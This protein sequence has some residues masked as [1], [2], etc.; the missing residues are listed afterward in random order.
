MFCGDGIKQA[1]EKCDDGNMNGQ[2]GSNCT[3]TCQFKNVLGCGNSILEPGEECDPGGNCVLNGS[4]TG[5]CSNP[6][7]GKQCESYGGALCH[8]V[9]TNECSAQ[10][11]LTQGNCGDGILQSARGEECD[12]GSNNGQSGFDCDTSC[13]YVR[14]PQCGDGVI[15]PLTEECDAGQF[16]GN[17][18]GASCRANCMLP[19]C[20]DAIVDPNEECDDGNN[21]DNDSCNADCTLP[22]GAAPPYYYTAVLTQPTTQG[23]TGGQQGYPYQT[24]VGTYQ[25]NEQ[26][27][28]IPTPARA[29]TGPGLVIFLA[30]GAAAGVGIVRRKFVK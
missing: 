25:Q 9:S 22:K 21:L 18:P 16:N 20:G 14:L 15:D 29:P 4:V 11:K 1:L 24:G 17:Y 23:Y 10:C 7:E 13:H 30:S 6:V 27:R 8:A 3:V 26:L 28:N 5:R 12:Q 19:R 2:I